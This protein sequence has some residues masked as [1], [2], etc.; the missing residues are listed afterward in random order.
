MP[1]RGRL[2]GRVYRARTCLAGAQACQDHLRRT[3]IPSLGTAEGFRGAFVLRHVDDDLVEFCTVTL[4][5]TVAAPRLEP[6]GPGTTIPRAAQRLMTEFEKRATDYE[7]V[8]QA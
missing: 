2:T 4:W 3:I 8:I 7:V 1:R 5:A 6:A